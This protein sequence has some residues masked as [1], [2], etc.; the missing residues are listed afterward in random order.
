MEVLL[1]N[2]ERRMCARHIWANWQKRWRGEERR[3]AFWR[4]SKA[5][6]E[7]KLR[8]EFEY[9]GKLGHKICEALLG[10]NKEYSCRALFSEKSKYDV[11]ENNMCETFNSWIV[12]PRHKFVISM[13]E[14]IRHKMMDRHG[15]MIK[16]ADTWISDISPMARLIF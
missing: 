2:A 6:I 9:L 7:V 14:D 11:V 13:L 1:P 3:K 12:S 16:F 8:D 4:C 5:S 10:Y 15:D